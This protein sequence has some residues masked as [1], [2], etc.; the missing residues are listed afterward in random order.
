MDLQYFRKQVQQRE[1][2]LTPE[3]PE[4]C[5][6]CS[7]LETVRLTNTGKLA[8]LCTLAG[9]DYLMSGP[10]D[11]LAQNGLPTAAWLRRAL[12]D[13]VTLD[14]NPGRDLGAAE[15]RKAAEQANGTCPILAGLIEQLPG[16][17]NDSVIRLE[18]PEPIIGPQ[19]HGPI[20]PVN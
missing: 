14:P 1:A 13:E 8:L 18:A 4:S 2:A 17:P 5:R 15:L 11:S 12:V 20:Q 6:G 7:N 19:P 9:T 10:Y 3:P 16:A